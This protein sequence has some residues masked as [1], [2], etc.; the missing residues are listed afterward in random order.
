MTNLEIARDLA[1]CMLDWPYIH[2]IWGLQQHN[3]DGRFTERIQSMVDRLF[4]FEIFYFIRENNALT[5]DF[6]QN[7]DDITVDEIKSLPINIVLFGSEDNPL[8][9]LK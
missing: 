2:D 4:P 5:M 7:F 1:D 3:T 6:Y 8:G 9:I